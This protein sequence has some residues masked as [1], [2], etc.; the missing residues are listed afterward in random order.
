MALRSHHLK[1]DIAMDDTWL[2]K[3]MVYQEIKKNIRLCLSMDMILIDRTFV[4]AGLFPV[5]HPF[6]S[7]PSSFLNS[8]HQ[9]LKQHL[10]SMSQDTGAVE[11]SC[12]QAEHNV[13]GQ[14]IKL[15]DNISTNIDDD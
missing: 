11:Y 1:L 2:T 12:L 6:T 3:N 5:S 14:H 10:A 8:S 4:V 15:E 13:S 7:T 9:I